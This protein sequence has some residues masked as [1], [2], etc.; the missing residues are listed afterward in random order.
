MRLGRLAAD[1]PRIVELDVNP[2]IAL[3]QPQGN[4][5]ADVRI[6]LGPVITA[7]SSA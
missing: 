5:I 7:E 2:L 6:R 1:F 3:P 4:R